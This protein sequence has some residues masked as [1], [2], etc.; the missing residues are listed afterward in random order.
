M[1][2]APP[3]NPYV[4]RSCE[5]GDCCARCGHVYGESDVPFV[6]FC[7][8]GGTLW[9]PQDGPGYWVEPSPRRRSYCAACRAALSVAAMDRLGRDPALAGVLAAQEAKGRVRH[10]EKVQRCQCLACHR[11]IALPSFRGFGS[12]GG[13]PAAYCCHG[14]ERRAALTRAKRR[15]LASKPQRQCL[16]CDEWFQ[17]RDKRQLHCSPACRVRA[18]RANRECNASRTAS[19]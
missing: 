18:W 19:P 11:A 15:R 7:P 17:P 12:F 1:L 4:E 14:C 5:R 9:F 2:Q 8:C 3:E 16:G 13:R 10:V 6:W